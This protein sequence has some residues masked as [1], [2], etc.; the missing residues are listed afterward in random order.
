M[1]SD[2]GGLIPLTQHLK[3]GCPLT[4]H[5]TRD[6]AF[7]SAEC[8]MQLA[9]WLQSDMQAEQPLLNS[10]CFNAGRFRQVS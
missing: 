5:V 8:S 3:S 2:Q 10:H 6:G 7:S 1:L 4:R 9:C